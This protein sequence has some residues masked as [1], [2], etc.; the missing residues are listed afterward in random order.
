MK[1]GVHGAIGA[2]FL[3]AAATVQAETILVVETMPVR[4]IE[5]QRCAFLES[6][7]VAD[8]SDRFEITRF[9][10]NGEYDRAISFLEEHRD[11][12]A[13]DLVLTFGTL[14]TQAAV[15][16]FG[17]ES[18]VPILFGVVADPVG[19]GVVEKMGVPSGTNVAGVVYTV[20]RAV[21][22]GTV[23]DLLQSSN[24]YDGVTVGIPHSSY[25]SSRG[26][27]RALR[28]SAR[29]FPEFRI[30]EREFPYV[31]VPEGLPAMQRDMSAA[32]RALEPDIDW[33]WE[34]AGPMAERPQSVTE[35]LALSDKPV[36]I[37]SRSE[38]VEKGA[39]ISI[40]PDA[41]GSGRR[42]AAMALEIFGGR[43]VGTIPVEPAPVFRVSV[44][45]GTALEHGI[46]VPAYLLELAGERVYR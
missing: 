14:A 37:A 16:V 6:L 31:P 2:F 5:R 45:V 9:Q 26:D 30:L 24:E 29:E 23:L 19:A 39:L 32:L 13:P 22:I 46:V 21:K 33:W 8:E 11:Q 20:D 10:A 35:I 4:A 34:A 7:A 42:L 3:I 43:D 25:P 40:A 1:R 28:E 27:V 44:N 12:Q 36:L 18:G 38:G 41:L 17:A 15:S